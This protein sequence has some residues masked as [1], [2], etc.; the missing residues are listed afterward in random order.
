MNG[1]TD[2]LTDE[3]FSWA[4]KTAS[5]D[6]LRGVEPLKNFSAESDPVPAPRKA[7]LRLRLRELQTPAVPSPGGGIYLT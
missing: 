6:G 2:G 1:R 4:I 3:L 7:K 5:L